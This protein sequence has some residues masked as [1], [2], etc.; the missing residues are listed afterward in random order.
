MKGRSDVFFFSRVR[1]V[2]K[3]IKNTRDFQMTL[4][5]NLLLKVK[6]EF[7]VKFS[8]TCEIHKN[9]ASIRALEISHV[10]FQKVRFFNFHY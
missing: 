6:K 1:C 7:L 10:L 9:F 8:Q 5:K 3:N 4:K 2:I